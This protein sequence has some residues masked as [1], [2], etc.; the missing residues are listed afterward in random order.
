[1]DYNKLHYYIRDDILV[2]FAESRGQ[3][4]YGSKYFAYIYDMRITI[5]PVD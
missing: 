1:M 5:G 4:I 2:G 3:F